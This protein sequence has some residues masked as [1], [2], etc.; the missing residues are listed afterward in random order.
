MSSKY[1]IYRITTKCGHYYVGKT[2]S[3]KTRVALHLYNSN[4][5][6]LRNY[7]QK[8]GKESVRVE[9]LIDSCPEPWASYFENKYAFE[10][11]ELSLNKA[12]IRYKCKESLLNKRMKPFCIG[13]SYNPL[14]I[15]FPYKLHTYL[16]S[17]GY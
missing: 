5:I 16:T 17:E 9:L 8:N 1:D 6:A 7:I 10:N 12:N 11:K 3:F 15:I 13:E 2:E 4:C 14:Q